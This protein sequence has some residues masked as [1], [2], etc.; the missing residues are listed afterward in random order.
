MRKR[1]IF[2]RATSTHSNDPPISI[3]DNL[4]YK[5]EPVFKQLPQEEIKILSSSGSYNS[6]KKDRGDNNRKQMQG[7]NYCQGFYNV[8]TAVCPNCGEVL[9][10]KLHA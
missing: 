7:C 3:P 1:P 5:N 2:Y 4:H 8:G 9:N 6:D 10:L